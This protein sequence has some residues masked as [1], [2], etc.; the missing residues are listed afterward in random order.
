MEPPP[1]SLVLRHP[2][3]GLY[4][5]K[6]L[7]PT[8]VLQEDELSPPVRP[9]AVALHHMLVLQQF[10]DADLL[11]DSVLGLGVAVKVNLDTKVKI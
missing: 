10:V 7:P 4:P 11:L 6:E 1:L 8:A 9:G 3:V 2:H 5:I